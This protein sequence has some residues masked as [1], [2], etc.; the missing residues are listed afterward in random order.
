VE[1][2]A[3]LRGRVAAMSCFS[4]VFDVRRRSQI[5][6]NPDDWKKGRDRKTGI[7]VR[8][9]IATA[10][11]GS[12]DEIANRHKILLTLSWRQDAHSCGD[13]IAHVSGQGRGSTGRRVR[14]DSASLRFHRT[15]GDGRFRQRIDTHGEGLTTFLTEAI[16]ANA[17][18]HQD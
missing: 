13:S 3:S 14:P 1:T 2:T 8:L 18:R 17:A 4:V 7:G 16:R 5:G 15:A 9:S 6:L 11:P 12:V 10:T